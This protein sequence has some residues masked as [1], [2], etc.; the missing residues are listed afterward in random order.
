MICPEEGRTKLL[1]ENVDKLIHWMSREDQT[2]SEILYWIPKYILM[3]G[4]RPLS[5][6]GFMSPQFK[7]LAASQDTIGWREFTEGHI[8]THFYAI[9]SFHLFEDAV[10]WLTENARR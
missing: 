5:E 8:S 3:R 2:D 4:D 6:M 10:E 7:A 9:Q 1:R